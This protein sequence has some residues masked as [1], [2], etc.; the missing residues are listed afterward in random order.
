MVK[1]QKTRVGV[2]L[3]DA[4]GGKK[5]SNNVSTDVISLTERYYAMRKKLQAL[6]AA[7][8]QHHFQMV[9]MANSRV[10]V[11]RPRVEHIRSI[12]R[13]VRAKMMLQNQSCVRECRR[14][15]RLSRLLDAVAAALQA[16]TEETNAND[17]CLS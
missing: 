4:I 2:I 9:E 5:K 15:G 13:D 3:K 8:K 1:T 7:L 10:E 14:I 17:G 6:I 11:R 16:Q 12:R